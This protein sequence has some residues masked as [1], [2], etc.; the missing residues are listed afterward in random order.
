MLAVI[1][2]LAPK[3]I[4]A[5][6]PASSLSRAVTG[7]IVHHLQERLSTVL[8]VPT[9]HSSLHVHSPAQQHS[10]SQRSPLTSMS[11]ARTGLTVEQVLLTLPSVPLATSAQV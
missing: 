1:V 5:H 9:A 7:H 3:A 10:P 8:Q 6:Q 11:C 4:I 2:L